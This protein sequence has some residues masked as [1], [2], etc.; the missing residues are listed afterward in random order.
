MAQVKAK[1]AAAYP[2]MAVPQVKPL[3]GGEVLGCTAPTLPADTDALVFVADGRF[4]LE[5][6]MIQN[7]HV[8][9]YRCVLRRSLVGSRAFD[10]NHGLFGASLMMRRVSAAAPR[11]DPYSRVLTREEYDQ[12]G[13]RAVRRKA[14]EAARKASRFGI[15]LGTLGRQGNPA[16]LAHLEQ[17]FTSRRLRYSVVLLSEISPAKLNAMSDV[18]AWVQIACPRLSIDWG[19]GFRI[20]VRKISGSRPCS[21]SR[22]PCR[23]EICA[24]SMD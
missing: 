22:L 10:L 17:L 15:I 8:P 7:P 3:S 21:P 9:A 24:L 1:L 19:E 2:H 13:M 18:E 12:A 6:I 23:G 14:I 5:S 4:H 20:P 16:I 11:Y